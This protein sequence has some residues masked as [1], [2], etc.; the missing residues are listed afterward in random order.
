LRP[1][2]VLSTH[3]SPRHW[4]RCTSTCRGAARRALRSGLQRRR[5][6]REGPFR[7]GRSLRR[8][9]RRVPRAREA[10]RADH[11]ELAKER[12]EIECLRVTLEMHRDRERAQTLGARA[13]DLDREA[14]MLFRAMET[15]AETETKIT[16][17]T[18]S[19]AA[20]RGLPARGAPP[21]GRWGPRRKPCVPPS[22]RASQPPPR[23]RAISASKRGRVHRR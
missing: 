16:D 1:A 3:G 5:R 9:R 6:R 19:A 7:H 22:Q 2:A 20:A 14:K 11:T 23:G 18:T 13:R 10:G 8:L 17:T 12:A 21:R 4:P 15:E